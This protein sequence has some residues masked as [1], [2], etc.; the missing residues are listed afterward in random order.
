MKGNGDYEAW[1]ERGVSADGKHNMA[2]GTTKPYTPPAT[3]QGKLNTTDP[4]SK[5]LKGRRG[6]VQ[7]YNAQAVVNEH[8][9]VLA[10]KPRSGICTA[11][12]A[13]CVASLVAP[14]DWCAVHPRRYIWVSG[15]FGGESSASSPGS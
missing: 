3:P 4:D 12:R 2:S 10:E 7:G 6:F 13:C 11:V 14:A 8:Q 5:L 9:D 15:R 1:R